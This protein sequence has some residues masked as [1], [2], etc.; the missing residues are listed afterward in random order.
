MQPALPNPSCRCEGKLCL[1]YG[2][3]TEAGMGCTPGLHQAS[4]VANLGL[5]AFRG[6]APTCPSAAGQFLRRSPSRPIDWLWRSIG[7][8]PGEQVPLPDQAWIPLLTHSTIGDYHEPCFRASSRTGGQLLYCEHG[9]APDAGV[10][11]AQN[12]LT[13]IWK[14]LAGGCHLNRP[15]Q[16]YISQAGFEILSNENQYLAKLPKFAAFTYS[17][18][19]VRIG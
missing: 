9:L 8:M 2:T 12:F 16:D 10:R 11:R 14:R 5:R 15:I 4:Q 7:W 18:R 19:A 13:P 6:H 1:C 3:V 17:G